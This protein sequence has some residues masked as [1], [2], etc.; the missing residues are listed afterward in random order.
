M[1]R[2]PLIPTI[3][4]ALAV[5]GMIALGVWQLQRAA[6]KEALLA[7]YAAHAGLPEIAFPAVPVR[8]A[9][10]L[11][12]R[13]AA[14]CL[15]VTGW[16]TRGG[17][18]L[19]GETGWR[20]IATCR[21]G[22]AEGPG[23]AVDLGWSRAID[24]PRGYVPGRVSGVIDWDRDRIF[25]LVADRPAPGLVA[26]APPSPADIPNNH[27]GYAMQWFI[28]ALVAAG[29]YAIALRSRRAAPVAEPP[30]QG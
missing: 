25:L 18:N 4:V 30:G 28:F 3:L 22:G 1:K 2:I 17:R 9:A 29:I 5:A 8:D 27:R 24:P 26:S 21:T 6:R 13:A 23:I 15:A 10:L 14:H 20:H 12:R 11:F 19:A 16:T 7:G